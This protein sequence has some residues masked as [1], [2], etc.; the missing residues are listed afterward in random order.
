MGVTIKDV[1]ERAGVSISTVSLVINGKGGVSDELKE[2]IE[3]A[4]EE[5]NYH[6]NA[7]ARGLKSKKSKVLGLVVPDILNPFFPQVIKGI[8]DAV[9]RYG[10]TLILGNTDGKMEEEAR[11]LHLFVEKCV[12]GIIFIP[13][14]TFNKNIRLFREIKVPKVVIDRALDDIKVST[15]MTDN[16]LGAYLGT[17][18]LLANGRRRIIFVSGPPN[19]Q[20]SKDRYAGYIKALDEFGI[21]EKIVEYGNFT[22]ESGKMVTTDA[23]EKKTKF[24]AIFAA[25]DMIAF[26]AMVV[27]A[28]K[29]IA[30]PEEV[31][32]IGYD[33]ILFSFLSKPSLTTIGQPA[34]DMG[35]EAVKIVLRE[36]FTKKRNSYVSK[37]LEPELIIR[38]SSPRRY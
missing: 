28:E 36:I 7:M 13:S 22:F 3:E 34:Y 17:R 23:L 25:N 6:P 38:E 12:E 31:E 11:Y 24:D 14:G 29:K 15:V 16:I 33:N 30:I 9:K 20:A 10:Y 27:L 8:E 37:L 4:V 35:Y 5:L 26:G 19:L 2:K 32:V 21:K 1:A 18:H